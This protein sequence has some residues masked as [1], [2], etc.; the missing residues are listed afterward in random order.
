[1]TF[2]IGK[3]VGEKSARRPDQF[4]K[5]AQKIRGNGAGVGVKMGRPIDTVFRCISRGPI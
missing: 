2:W 3:L 5:T 4:E 1:M